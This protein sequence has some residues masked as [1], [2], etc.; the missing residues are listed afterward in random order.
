MRNAADVID[1]IESVVLNW[2]HYAKETGVSAQLRKAIGQ[3]I[4]GRL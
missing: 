3:T 4:S 2:D 1:E